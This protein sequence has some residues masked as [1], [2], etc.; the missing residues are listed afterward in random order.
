MSFFPKDVEQYCP[1]LYISRPTLLIGLATA[2]A[3]GLL[4]AILPAWRAARVGI[5][6]ALRRVG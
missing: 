2:L 6:A 3:V 1:G 5:A 4:A